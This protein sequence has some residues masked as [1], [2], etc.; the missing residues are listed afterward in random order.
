MIFSHFFLKNRELE[1]DKETILRKRE[2]CCQNISKLNEI[3]LNDKDQFT[4]MKQLFQE[5]SIEKNQLK[6]ISEGK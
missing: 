1:I 4:F 5:I 2:I 3:L 6:S